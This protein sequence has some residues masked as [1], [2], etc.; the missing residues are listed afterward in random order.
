[1]R[2][3]RQLLATDEAQ[4]QVVIGA[5]C[6]AIFALLVVAAFLA[7]CRHAPEPASP[8]DPDAGIFTAEGRRILCL[9]TLGV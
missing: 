3:L 6:G 4:E 2:R 8:Y 5:V 9:R 7:G 1:M